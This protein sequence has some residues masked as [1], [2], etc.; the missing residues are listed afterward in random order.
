MYFTSRC[1]VRLVN[2]LLVLG[3]LKISQASAHPDETPLLSAFE[4]GLLSPEGQELLSP[5]TTHPERGVITALIEFPEKGELGK[6]LRREFEKRGVEFLS[7]GIGH[8]TTTPANMLVFDRLYGGRGIEL[9][10]PLHFLLDR[11]GTYIRAAEA[12]QVYGLR[13]K[14]VLIG[15]ADTGIDLS[16]PDF[17]DESGKTRVA[18]VLDLTQAP[19]GLYPDLEK[20]YGVKDG[21]GQVIKGA[22]LA[23]ADINASLH[24][25]D[26]STVDLMGHGTH[27]A[28]IAAGNGRAHQDKRY[29]G[30]APEATLIVA[31]VSELVSGI[32]VQDLLKG[33]AFLFDRANEL[34][35]PIVVNL[36]MG[37]TIGPH[38]GTSLWEQE[39][40]S[41]VG[42]DKPGRAIVVAAGNMGL[43][44]RGGTHQSVYVSEGN[45]MRVPIYTT[46]SKK[47]SV[48]IWVSSNQTAEIAIGLD[49]PTGFSVPFV[50]LRQVDFTLEQ[51]SRAAVANYGGPSAHNA[52]KH[53]RIAW[54]GPWPA[55]SYFVN[56]RGWGVVDLY[57]ASNEADEDSWTSFETGVRMGTV[58]LPAT[59]PNLIAVG[60]T[61]S[62]S[63][64]TAIDQ[65]HYQLVRP[66]FDPKSGFLP[67]GSEWSPAMDGDI[68]VFSGAGPTVQG[69]PKPE[70]AA[71]GAVIIGA[72]SSQT[73]LDEPS[74]MLRKECTSSFSQGQ[75]R[76]R[77][78]CW[79]MDPYYALSMGS[80]M[81]SPAVA[82]A[83]ALF[84]EQY[85]DLTQGKIR[86]ILQAGAHYFRGSA[87]FSDQSSLGELD[88]MGS[89]Q[90]LEQIQNPALALP[91]RSTS[92]L[93]LSSEFIHAD[94]SRP[95][96]ALLRLQAEDGQ[97][98]ADG[99]DLARLE[100][101]VVLSGQRQPNPPIERRG[102]GLFSFTVTVP[103]GFGGSSLTVYA[104][105]DGEAIVEPKTIS[106]AV[107]PWRSTYP[108]LVKGGCAVGLGSLE[109]GDGLD[110][111]IVGLLGVGG[112]CLR[113]Q[114]RRTHSSLRNRS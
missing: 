78:T 37:S 90:V 89:L 28:S 77:G 98:Q 47:G 107:D 33:V 6:K 74:S 84:F 114:C 26:L 22:V 51:N 71:P 11:V 105:F 35:Q 55:G 30:V 86:D 83:V 69:V 113:W 97:H 104:L 58:T 80:S 46:G 62:R 111:L 15:V 102:P 56:L 106:V 32:D 109:S 93:F 5:F 39:L 34:H 96:Y 44:V 112:V 100:P 18:W 60:C 108:S 20:K 10:F 75:K 7:P 103:A 88:V 38:D 41:Y 85:P 14:G 40:A 87:P 61:I 8:L 57:L 64:W 68:C 21:D 91:S 25:G 23:A 82:G 4:K 66:L 95:I 16:H 72:M 49:M 31:R 3:I 110:W 59:H 76:E 73:T 48:N 52:L 24:K 50:E 45:V 9:S 101:F 81:S 43:P 12:R 54:V 99:F 19:L 67:V 42:E 79:P 36:S 29:M 94:G 70:I 13:G 17:I 53:A 1:L 65:T 27:V 92:W 2:F 63:P